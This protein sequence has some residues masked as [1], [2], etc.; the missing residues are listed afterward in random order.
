MNELTC[1]LIQPVAKPGRR[2]QLRYRFLRSGQEMPSGIEAGSSE[3]FRITGLSLGR[4]RRRFRG[5]EANDNH[6]IVAARLERDAAQAR[7]GLVK[8]QWTQART[9]EVNELKNHGL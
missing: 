5:I 8:A 6:V 7:Y 1:L 3:F 4:Q 9:P 2:S